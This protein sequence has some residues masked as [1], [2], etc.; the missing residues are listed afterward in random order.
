[1]GYLLLIP[2]VVL[3]FELAVYFG[4]VDSRLDSD[5]GWLTPRS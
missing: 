5:R 1:M 2:A 4:G 3:L